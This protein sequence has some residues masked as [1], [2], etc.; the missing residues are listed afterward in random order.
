M[1]PSNCYKVGQTKASN[2]KLLPLF[3]IIL[4]QNVNYL[5]LGDILSKVLF[6]PTTNIEYIKKNISN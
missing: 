3:S 6:L 1:I 5:F 2:L 4:L